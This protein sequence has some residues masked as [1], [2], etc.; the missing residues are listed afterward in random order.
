MDS[1][2]FAD[3]ARSGTAPTAVRQRPGDAATDPAY[4]AADPAY[5]PKTRDVTGTADLSELN[6][7]LR[8]NARRKGPS[9]AG[10]VGNDE[11]AERFRKTQGENEFRTAVDR[12]RKPSSEGFADRRYDATG[13]YGG[14]PTSSTAY[15]AAAGDAQQP[16]PAKKSRGKVSDMFGVFDDGGT[17]SGTG[18]GGGAGAVRGA[19]GV[20][21]GKASKL[22]FTTPAAAGTASAASLGTS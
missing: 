19:A 8:V 10:G 4:S 14:A 15:G 16:V 3:L 17:G 12:I 22:F 9:A 20:G 7:S 11:V 2:M 13:A 1:S 6:T 5:R 21:A 18:S